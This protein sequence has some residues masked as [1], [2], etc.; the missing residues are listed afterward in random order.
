[1][2]MLFGGVF[3]ILVGALMIAA[4]AVASEAVIL[5]MGIM[6]LA[7]GAIG[8]GAS[9]VQRAEGW[10]WGLA[11]G[12]LSLFLG[13]VFL[14]YQGQSL[15]AVTLFVTIYLYISGIGRLV[16]SFKQTGPAK[17]MGI[18]SA[19]ITLLLAILITAS[20]PYSAEIVLGLFVG[21]DILFTGIMML[22]LGSMYPKGLP[23]NP[24]T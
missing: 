5:F 22:M 1:M 10:L 21:I 11:G 6:L 7:G 14:M 15:V 23:G 2:F 3:M 4:P 17:G 9:I 12:L 16:L 24:A 19:L 13:I 18:F 20:W 8:I